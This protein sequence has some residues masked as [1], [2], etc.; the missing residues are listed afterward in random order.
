MQHILYLIWKNKMPDMRE[1]KYKMTLLMLSLWNSHMTN[2]R[3]LLST[4]EKTVN[5]QRID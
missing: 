1:T 3:I 4:F 5:I 2:D